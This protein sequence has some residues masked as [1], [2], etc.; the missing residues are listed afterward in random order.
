[1]KSQLRVSSA[2]KQEIQVDLVEVPKNG[3]QLKL[4]NVGKKLEPTAGQSWAKIQKS[5][6]ENIIQHKI[7]PKNFSQQNLKQQFVKQQKNSKQNSKL[8]DLIPKY[9]ASV[10]MQKWQNAQE[11]RGATSL[12]SEKLADAQTYIDAETEFIGENKEWKFLGYLH[13]RIDSHL[14]FDSLLAQWSHFGVVYVQFRV[15]RDGT[16]KNDNLKVV[17]E[18]DVLKVHVMRALRKALGVPI[19]PNKWLVGE[20]SLII[21]S[22]FEFMQNGPDWNRLKQKTFTKNALVFRRA[23]MESP[24][25][26][27]L[28]D[29]LLS[30][31]ISYDPF[32]MY[33][34]WQKYNKKQYHKQTEFDPFESYRRDPDYNL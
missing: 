17:A 27:N 28:K 3:G 5:K 1:M 18:D 16:L 21:Y 22:K 2:N 31:G 29:H 19:D 34:R 32:A 11:H 8:R 12:N 6:L 30:G 26:T 15:N 24:I 14:L 13:E 20:D 23:T 9:E 7:K 33:D 25:P 4:E 10:E